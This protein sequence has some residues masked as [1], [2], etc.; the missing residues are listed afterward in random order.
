MSRSSYDVGER[1]VSINAPS[2]LVGGSRHREQH[3]K[4]SYTEEYKNNVGDIQ[5]TLSSILQ[6]SVRKLVKEGIF[7]SSFEIE[8][9]AE[10]RVKG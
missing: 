5:M 8:K 3:R 7:E 4:R 2:S 6:R 1:R 9:Q 10:R